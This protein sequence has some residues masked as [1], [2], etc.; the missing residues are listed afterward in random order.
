[1]PKEG[2]PQARRVIRVMD[3]SNTHGIQSLYEA[4]LAEQPR[5]AAT[6]LET[7]H[8]PKDDGRLNIA[9]IGLRTL[10]AQCPNRRIPDLDLMR[11]W[12]RP[13][14][15]DRN[16]RHCPVNWQFAGCDARPRLKSLYPKDEPSKGNSFRGFRPQ[17]RLVA[18]APWLHCNLKT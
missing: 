9:E 8:T 14:G 5:A 1:M 18:R 12:V 11:E 10:C 4:H 13:Y 3:N 7:H 6:R 17:P 2:H 16:E 15:K